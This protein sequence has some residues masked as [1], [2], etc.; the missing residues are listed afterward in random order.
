MP[1][2]TRLVEWVSYAR[3][4]PRCD[5]VVCHGGHGTV[6]RALASG[7]AVVAVPAAGDM[8]ENAARID[9]A[10]VGVRVPRR[11]TRPG[12]LRLAVQRAL[13][14]ERIGR[15]V[16]ELAAWSATHDGPSRAADLVEVAGRRRAYP[17]R[18][19]F[20]DLAGMTS[21]SPTLSEM[22]PEQ[23]VPSMV[24]LKLPLTCSPSVVSP[25]Q[26][27]L[28]DLSPPPS[29]L[30]LHVRPG[31]QVDARLL[32]LVA[33]L[34]E[35]DPRR[36]V[37]DGVVDL[38]LDLVDRSAGGQREGQGR[39]DDEGRD[40]AALGGAAGFD[41]AGDATRRDGRSG[42]GWTDWPDGGPPR[43]CGRAELRGWDSNPQP[44]G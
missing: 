34:A 33:H 6:V 32:E 10:G 17:P 26:T 7:C 37:P 1:P 31:L 40:T 15:R 29:E 35:H 41:H 42:S 11:F 9:W 13:W 16:R 12:A 39:K 3:T 44:N 21:L 4:M 36:R 20:S 30:S 25:V 23:L 28:I 27:M 2:N 19:G 8:N 43:S 18:Q 14:D 22:L 38:V 5:V 24:A